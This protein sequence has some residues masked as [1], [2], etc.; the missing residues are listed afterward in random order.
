M[1]HSIL[2]S[3][4]GGC[5]YL[6][7]SAATLQAAEPTYYY[8]QAQ[9][10][11]KCVHQN[12][13]I[14]DNGGSVS[15]WE[16]VNQGNVKLE[17]VEVGSGY[18]FL[19]FPHSKKCL[20]VRDD[21]IANDIPLI[22]YECVEGGPR[23]QTWREVKTNTPPFVKIESTLGTCLHQKG[24]ALN[25]GGELTTWQCID[26]AN[27]HWQFIVAPPEQDSCPVATYSSGKLHIP[28]VE[29]ADSSFVGVSS[30]K[31]DMDLIN[32]APLRFELTKATRNP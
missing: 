3:A 21:I 22:Q 8:L 13:N 19:R 30:Y 2:L 12:G 17:R 7:G 25:N 14:Q 20:T 6:L 18:F 16:C 9:H 23:N 15:Q 1:K 27:L 26:Q 28:S 24:I 11:G 29:V 31:V 32:P 10:S 4:L 5:C